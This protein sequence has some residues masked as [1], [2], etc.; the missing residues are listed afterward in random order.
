MSCHQASCH[1]QPAY[2]QVFFFSCLDPLQG[3]PTLM[4]WLVQTSHSKRGNPCLS[5]SLLCSVLWSCSVGLAGVCSEPPPLPPS[6]EEGRAETSEQQAKAKKIGNCIG[7]CLTVFIVSGHPAQTVYLLSYGRFFDHTDVF[8]CL[9]PTRSSEPAD[10]GLDR[11]NPAQR[12]P[13][14]SRCL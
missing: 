1:L 7:G 3:D 13:T 9:I 14:P 10:R 6:G 5:L 11:T 4:K 12:S 2:N 8:C